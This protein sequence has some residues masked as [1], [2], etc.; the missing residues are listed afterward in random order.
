MAANKEWIVLKEFRNQDTGCIA[1]IGTILSDLSSF[2]IARCL[3]DKSIAPYTHIEEE[4]TMK[5]NIIEK[6]VK[7]ISK[8]RRNKKR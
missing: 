1:K 6:T 4:N 7:R 5:K 2:Q 8:Q 3:A